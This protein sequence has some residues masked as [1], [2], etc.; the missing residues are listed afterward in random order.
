MARQ[1]RRDF[2]K[3][4]AGVPAALALGAGA[5]AAAQA[6]SRRPSPACGADTHPTPAQTEGPYFKPRSPERASLLEPG[7]AGAKIVVSG[8]VLSTDCKPVPRA[9]VDLWHA[10]DRGEYDNAGYRLRGHQ[11]TDDEG[12]YRFET[13]VP[14]NYPGRTRH[15]HVKVQ[16]PNRPPLTTQLYFPGEP[17]NRRDGIFDPDL[18]MKVDDGAGGKVGTYTFVLD[19]TG[20][21]RSRRG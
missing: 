6:P 12:R 13:I 3:I 21:S 17:A 2:L 7:V 19:L 1:T 4:T 9:L 11:F 18:V 8:V 20:R 5:P 15:Y 14:G 10:D 16:A